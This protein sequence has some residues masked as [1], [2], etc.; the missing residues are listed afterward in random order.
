MVKG[1]SVE[2]EGK[3]RGGRFPGRFERS[4]IR[5]MKVPTSTIP[6]SLSSGRSV[7]DIRLDMV[8]WASMGK[9]GERVVVPLVYEKQGST[10]VHGVTYKYL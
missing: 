10:S 9:R 1:I 8:L 6:H 3:I 4:H 7:E 5:L 2:A